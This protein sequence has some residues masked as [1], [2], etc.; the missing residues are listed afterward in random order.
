MVRLVFRP[1]TQVRRSICTLESIRPSTRVSPGFGLLRHSS[2]S[3][4]SQHICSHSNLSSGESW[5]VDSAQKFLPQTPGALY[6]NSAL[7]VELRAL[8]HMLDSLVRVSRRDVERHFVRVYCSHDSN[9][10]PTGPEP[11][12]RKQ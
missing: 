7:G 5:S 1:Y 12:P 4:G 11:F 10:V 9:P 6:V 8:A 2:P 3:F